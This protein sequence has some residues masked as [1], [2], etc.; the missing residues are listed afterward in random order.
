[1]NIQGST[2][3]IPPGLSAVVTGAGS[4]VGAAVA[5]ALGQ[6]GVQVGLLGRRETHLVQAAAAV[7]QAGGKA[8][9]FVC[10][11]TQPDS[12]ERTHAE[13]TARFGTV[14]VLV[15][16]AGI[17]TELVPIAESTP[18][19]WIQTINTN[20]TGTYLACRAFV[21]GMLAKG[22]GRIINVSSAAALADPGGVAS[23]YQLSKVTV[24]YFTRQLAAE[25]HG[26]GVTANALHPGEVKTEMWASIK[27]DASARSGPGR[28]ALHW[29]GWVE[30][31]GGD[32]PEKAAEVVLSL[33]SP[34]ADDINGRFLWIRDGLQP[35][36]PSW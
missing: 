6:N 33:L 7:R 2:I 28:D 19:A 10:D 22:W 3:S 23:A 15:N 35:P 1:M 4:G 32:P 24:N 16:C 25:L 21:G 29:A 36:K 5:R 12:I 8:E 11:V 30:E 14:Q 18:A 17:H 34:A 27:A 9:C 20:V 13:V 26:S 31:T